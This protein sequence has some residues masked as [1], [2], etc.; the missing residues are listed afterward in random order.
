MKKT[1]AVL[2]GILCLCLIFV[3]CSPSGDTVKLNLRVKNYTSKTDFTTKI[4]NGVAYSWSDSKGKAGEGTYSGDTNTITIN[5]SKNSSV[6]VTFEWK[7]S[8]GSPKSSSIKSL[9]V[10]T[11]D[12]LTAI[13]LGL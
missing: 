8:S 13:D 3:S 2:F 6:T 5:P 10:G 11:S 12:L 7:D 1:F 9:A 4:P